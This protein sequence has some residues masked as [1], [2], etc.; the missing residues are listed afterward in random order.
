MVRSS[1]HDTDMT[2]TSYVILFSNTCIITHEK[3]Y[4]LIAWIDMCISLNISI[5][6][7]PYCTAAGRPRAGLYA[8]HLTATHSCPRPIK[9]LLVV[10][11]READKMIIDRLLYLGVLLMAW[12]RHQN[13]EVV[14]TTADCTN[15]TRYEIWYVTYALSNFGSLMYSDVKY[16][17]GLETNKSY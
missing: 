9:V 4:S 11:T 16:S 12:L 14:I 8:S 1:V 15:S 3:N 10:V 2:L 13:A 6:L 17:I 7:S 5:P